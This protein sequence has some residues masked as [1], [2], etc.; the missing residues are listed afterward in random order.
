MRPEDALP[1]ARR[2]AA[3]AR[4]AGGYADADEVA[5]R[6][7]GPSRAAFAKLYDWAFIEPDRDQVV[8]TR[9]LG[10]PITVLKRTLMRLLRQY[11]GQLEGEQTR[12]NTHMVSYAASLERRIEALEAERER[13]PPR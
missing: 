3:A 1:E 12:F 4:E 7:R 2:R 11:H 5:T 10:W 6:G 9:R 8:S 13:E